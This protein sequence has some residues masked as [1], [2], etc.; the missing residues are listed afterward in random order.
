ML[1]VTAVF[2]ES[3]VQPELEEEELDDELEVFDILPPELEEELDELSNDV[4]EISVSGNSSY[5]HPALSP[6]TSV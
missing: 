1:R 6:S 3:I 2:V 4:M 5:H